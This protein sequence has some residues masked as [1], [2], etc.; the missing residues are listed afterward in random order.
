MPWA[1]I[2]ST[3]WVMTAESALPS[4]TNT[5]APY[6]SLAYFWA[7]A[8]C[9]WWNTLLRSDTKKAIF[10]GL[11]AGSCAGSCAAGAGVAGVPQADKMRLASINTVNR[12]DTFLFIVD[13]SLLFAEKNERLGIIVP[14]GRIQRYCGSDT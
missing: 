3:F 9:A 4:N 7:S 5:S 2:W 13:F 14:V 1:R 11:V 6:F 12:A 8:A 10:I